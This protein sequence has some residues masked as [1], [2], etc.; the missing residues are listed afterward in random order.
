MRGA[1]IAEDMPV[2]FDRGAQGYMQ[3][4]FM[5]TGD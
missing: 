1:V 2:W 5:A 4:G 3:W